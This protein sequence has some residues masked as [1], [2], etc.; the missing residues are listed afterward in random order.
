MHINEN[1][2]AEE[3]VQAPVVCDSNSRCPHTNA[4]PLVTIGSNNVVD[5]INESSEVLLS[6]AV[7][8]VKDIEGKPHLCSVLLDCG[9]IHKRKINK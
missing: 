6:T 3:R 1:V 9:K 5:R 2:K 8:C 7:V 4:E